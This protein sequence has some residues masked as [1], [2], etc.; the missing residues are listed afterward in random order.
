MNKKLFRKTIALLCIVLFVF[1]SISFKYSYA[2]ATSSFVPKKILIVSP[3]EDDECIACAGV[4]RKAIM[5]GNDVRVMFVTNGNATNIAETRIKESITALAK[6]GLSKD[7]IYYLSYGDYSVMDSLREFKNDPTRVFADMFGYTQTYGFPGVINDYHYVLTGTHATYCRQN[8]MFDM[9]SIINTFR[10]DD[11]YMPSPFE[12]HLDH[13]AAGVLTIET[14]MN[15][16]KSSSYSPMIHE[17]MI[18]KKGLPQSN[19]NL[20]SLPVLNENCDASMDFTSPYS[21]ND[22]ESVLVPDDMSR[23]QTASMKINLVNAGAQF[24]ANSPLYPQNDISKAFDGDSTTMYI[25]SG[26]KSDSIITVSFSNPQLIEKVRALIG[27]PNDTLNQTNVTLEAA[28]NLNDLNQKVK[29]YRLLAKDKLFDGTNWNEIKSADAYNC[30]VWRFTMHNIT[31]GNYVLIPE[32]EFD[33]SNLKAA[34]LREFVSQ[35]IGQ[36]DK[37]SMRDEIFWKKDMSNL[38]YPATVT[39]SSENTGPEQ[40]LCSKVIDGIVLGDGIYKVR[41]D[42]YSQDS[43]RIDE[44]TQNWANR[45]YEWK[46]KG[47]TSGAW[48]QLTWQKTITANRIMLYDRPDLDENITGG[49]LVFSDGSSI[50]LPTLNRNGSATT[51]DF[52]TKTFSWVKLVID[53]TEGTNAGLAEFEVY[54]R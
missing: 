46:T 42:A 10:P 43:T 9:Q 5:D 25:S 41:T 54:K 19:L 38:A 26:T 7:K 51:I 40:Q 1:T 27:D 6:L 47:E 33:N 4:I 53:K 14:V 36:Y 28:D 20:N 35:V 30:K 50:N 37:R 24:T 44:P 12:A 8:I 39:A 49:K 17:Y 18:Y 21:W 22:R 45:E 32:I 23:V 52:G 48:V 13:K 11:I 31:N 29:S 2:V 15:I 3:H 34:A 16:K